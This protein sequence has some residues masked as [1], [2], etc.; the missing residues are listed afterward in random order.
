MKT[1]LIILCLFFLV[2]CSKSSYPTDFLI[3]LD[4]NDVATEKYQYV[5]Y[6]KQGDGSGDSPKNAADFLSTAFWD[7]VN[8]L[9]EKTPVHVQFSEGSYSRSY[10]EKTLVLSSIGNSQNRLTLQGV[11]GKTVFMAPED[12]ALSKSS[13]FDIKNSQNIHVKNISFTGSGE[14]GYAFRV[15]SDADKSAKNILIENCSWTDM[16]GIIYG[17]AG[18]HQPGT[19]HVTFL[20]CTFK[21]IGID[22]H[23]HH[24]YNAY[25]TSYVSVVD[26]HFEDCTGDYVRFR[27]DMDYALVSG[28]TFIRNQGFDGKVFIS[29]PLFNSR[30]PV[31]D[32][33][34][35]TNYAF[36]NNSFTNNAS[37]NTENAITFYHAGFSPPEW[38]YLLTAEE[39]NTL[40]TGSVTDKKALLLSNFGIDTDKVRIS[41]NT[42]S[43]KIVTK[44][45]LGTFVSYGAISKGF[46]GWADITDLVNSSTQPF[47]WEDR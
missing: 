12:L 7:K 47:P 32:E 37:T 31:G 33:Y 41:G 24:I 38:N 39:G 5:S 43:S 46:A 22:S 40:Q 42:Y 2:S 15:T 6:V 20:N 27:D 10:T 17:A 19:S 21:R 30:E 26:S 25:G 34:F 18:A 28:S 13:L 45:A 4:E 44:V 1:N 14:L 3:T 11:D 36:T 29:V 35:R 8:E 23:S 16:R 9:L